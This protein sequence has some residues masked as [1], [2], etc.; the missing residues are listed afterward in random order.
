MIKQV[1]IMDE[2]EWMSIKTKANDMLEGDGEVNAIPQDVKQLVHTLI[3]TGDNNTLTRESLTVS[4][5]G[6]LR[7][8]PGFPWTR[9]NQGI[10]P[11]AARAV[12]DQACSEIEAA[13]RYFWE[14]TEQYSTPFLRKHGKSKG[15][16]TYSG[17]EEYAKTLA[18]KAR[19]NAT[20]LYKEGV[21]DGTQ[22]GL[23]HAHSD[24]RGEEE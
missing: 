2:L 8:Y 17:A 10:L 6:M 15:S 16:P 14:S 24:V 12:V 13:A 23:T 18:K 5:K 1:I 7:P 3:A 20:Q 9:G 22:V 4:L 11:A 19:Q 21:W